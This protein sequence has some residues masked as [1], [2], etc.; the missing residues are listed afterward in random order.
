MIVWGS[1]V[2]NVYGCEP[3]EE[4]Y[5]SQLQTSSASQ[6]I[7]EPPEPLYELAINSQTE[8]RDSEDLQATLFFQILHEHYTVPSGKLKSCISVTRFFENVDSSDLNKTFYEKYFFFKFGEGITKNTSLH[9][10]TRKQFYI[11]CSKNVLISAPPVSSSSKE[12]L[13]TEKC[14][15][16]GYEDYFFWGLYELTGGYLLGPNYL[17]AK[18]YFERAIEKRPIYPAEAT[19]ELGRLYHYGIEGQIKPEL[20]LAEQ[21]YKRAV[22][23]IDGNHWRDPRATFALYQICKN[24]VN[25][26]NEAYTWALDAAINGHGD[27]QCEV[28]RALYKGRGID[29]DD[30][31][32]LKWCDHAIKRGVPGAPML[33]AKILWQSPTQK[34]LAAAYKLINDLAEQRQNGKALYYKGIFYH[35]GIHVSKDESVAKQCFERS[36][37]QGC[38]Y[39]YSEYA[40]NYCTGSQKIQIYKKA[41]ELYHA[42]KKVQ[43][44][45]PNALVELEQK[46]KDL[47][48]AKRHCQIVIDAGYLQGLQKMAELEKDRI[49]AWIW[50]YKLALTKDESYK[51]YLREEFSKDFFAFVHNVPKAQE[52]QAGK[53]QKS[54]EDAFNN[55][56]KAAK[57]TALDK[58]FLTFDFSFY[59]S[60]F[61]Q[62]DV[63]INNVRI[64]GDLKQ[65]DEKEKGVEIWYYD[66]QYY[67]IFGDDNI[68]KKQE[69]TD[70]LETIKNQVNNLPN[71]KKPSSSSLLFLT[72]DEKIYNLREAYSTF[73]SL[74]Y[75]YIYGVAWKRNELFFQKFDNFLWASA[76][77]TNKKNYLKKS[78]PFQ[79]LNQEQFCRHFFLDEY[80]LKNDLVANYLSKCRGLLSQYSKSDDYLWAQRSKIKQLNA[81]LDLLE[82]PGVLVTIARFKDYQS[83][84]QEQFPED[85]ECVNFKLD[86]ECFSILGYGNIKEFSAFVARMKDVDEAFAAAIK[87]KEVLEICEQRKLDTSK[88]KWEQYKN[89]WNNCIKDGVNTRNKI[90]YDNYRKFFSVDA[91]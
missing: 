71:V 4:G 28:A 61:Q 74:N 49:K 85:A 36:G 79:N 46:R 43:P 21:C 62:P 53:L 11:D 18:H 57:G 77:N 41:L 29:K 87:H 66:N 76:C 48:K 39:G 16:P 40:L 91:I 34:N 51:T 9:L 54:W 35:D 10:F 90:F 65:I 8:I 33:K 44:F 86:S 89:A 3:K 17:Q 1:L 70:A 20:E 81:P 38:A 22:Y 84:A 75:N 73:N 52:E 12:N 58:I 50:L 63:L 27:A 83:Y 47:D 42:N 14:I 45:N 55:L 2:T 64:S 56:K 67:V 31:Q 72:E 24:D 15:E 19:F 6:T 26:S 82:K 32:A 69:Y 7:Q 78:T 88:E 37:K 5:Q 25:R 60:F 68:K 59:R 23:D 13:Q 30:E 80:S